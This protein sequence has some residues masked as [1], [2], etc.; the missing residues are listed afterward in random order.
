SASVRCWG[1]NSGGQLGAQTTETCDI[2]HMTTCSTTP[3]V[4]D[5]DSDMDG[6]VNS[7]E[8]GGNA[9]LGGMRNTKQF[10]DFFDTPTNTGVRD[11]VIST[12]DLQR[13]VSRFGSTQ[14]PA[15]TFSAA[16]AQALGV[17]AATGYNAAFDR[18]A[19]SPGGD[20][21]DLNAPDGSISAGDIL[22][23]INQFGHS[24]A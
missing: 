13:L 3:L 21:W 14:S 7:R 18:A 9:A 5:L 22:F 23:L 11:R 16:L 24:C 17:P 10:W 19:P 2:D 12:G 4:V 8:Q 1:E 6:C 15:P 20:P